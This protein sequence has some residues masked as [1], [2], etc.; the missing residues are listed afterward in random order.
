MTDIVE[1]AQRLIGHLPGVEIAT[2]WGR[3]ALKVSGRSFA[4]LSRVPGAIWVLCPLEL[5]EML[6][7]A[8]PEIF[9]ETDHYRGWPAILVRMDG[10]DDEAI[11]ARLE[12]AWADGAEVRGSS[13]PSVVPLPMSDA[14]AVDPEEA[15]VAA[16]SSCHMLWFLSLAHD[17]GF[18]VASYRDEAQGVI[19][20]DERGK[21]AMTTIRL[22]PEIAFEGREP[23]AAEL[24]GLHH[25]AH[26]KCFIANSLRCEVVVE[27]PQSA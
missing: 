15:L 11:A 19:G 24:A 8:A 23:A 21:I 7:E 18:I 26:D 6:M 27:E 16:A 22:R 2:S 12:A 25:E 4:G 5:K 10:G 3:P 1:R 13:S 9:F 17:A 14:A 20:R